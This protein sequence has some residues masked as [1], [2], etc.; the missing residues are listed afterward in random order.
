MTSLAASTIEAPASLGSFLDRI[1]AIYRDSGGDPARIPW[2]HRTACP[3]MVNWLNAAAP[4]LIRPGA[5]V[6]VVGCGLGLDACAL[7]DRGYDV[8]AFD[9]CESAIE[10]ARRLHPERSG[11]FTVA[12]AI[13]P[14]GR[15]VHRFDLV[16]EVHTIQGVPPEHREALARGIGTMLSHRGL[17]LAVARGRAEDSPIESVEGPPWSLTVG[18]MT[19]LMTGAG[20]APVRVDDFMDDN[21]PPVR[22]LRGL[23]R[24]GS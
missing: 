15:F 10:L 19:D 22:R 21:R 16:V 2:A 13:D 3:A 20:L 7:A 14:P 24:R 1:D 4:S 6:G 12:D 9:I 11:M 18:E 8:T 17:L 5:R 23:F